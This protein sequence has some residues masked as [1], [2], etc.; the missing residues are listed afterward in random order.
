MVEMEK[1]G[2]VPSGKV[3]KVKED[4]NMRIGQMQRLNNQE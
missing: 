1:Q 3:G 2:K 4:G